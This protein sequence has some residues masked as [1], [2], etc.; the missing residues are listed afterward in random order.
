MSRKI[1]NPRAHGLLF[2][3]AYF[4]NLLV[5]NQ[6]EISAQP[7]LS[8][9]AGS[10]DSGCESVT[11]TIDVDYQFNNMQCNTINWE[12]SYAENGPYLW[13]YFSQ[14]WATRSPALGVHDE[15]VNGMSFDVTF[16]N[17]YIIDGSTYSGNL[18]IRAKT[19]Q[20]C[21]G[22]GQPV[23]SNPVLVRVSQEQPS[24]SQAWSNNTMCTGETFDQ[25]FNPLSGGIDGFDWTSTVASGNFSARVESGTI[26]FPSNTTSYSWG[27]TLTNTSAE[28]GEVEY[29]F[30]PK[31][32]YCSNPNDSKSFTVY[33]EPSV[34]AGTLSIV[35][36]Q[37]FYCEGSSF[38]LSVQGASDGYD[39]VYQKDSDSP[40]TW[41]L[42]AGGESGLQVDTFEE[43]TKFRVRI[44]SECDQPTY[45]NEV[46][47]NYQA[48]PVFEAPASTVTLSRCSGVEVG[49]SVLTDISADLSWTVTNTSGLVSGY[50]TGP[51]L[52][53]V[54]SYTIDD[55]LVNDS[56]EVESITY[57]FTAEKNGCSSAVA[58]VIVNVQPENKAGTLSVLTPTLCQSA[59]SQT[60]TLELDGREGA[61]VD[62]LFK[63]PG[64]SIFLITNWPNG[65]AQTADFDLS[66]YTQTSTDL[67]YEFKVKSKATSCILTED[68]ESDIVT[69]T[70]KAIPDLTVS[71]VDGDQNTIADGAILCHGDQIS[72][73]ASSSVGD[74]HFSWSRQ[75]SGGTL[76][77]SNGTETGETVT[78]TLNNTGSSDATVVYIISPKNDPNGANCIGESQTFS[79]TIKPQSSHGDLTFNSNTTS[80]RY[81]VGESVNIQV[82]AEGNFANQVE[83]ERR[84]PGGT[85][86]PL[87]IKTAEQSVNVLI[88]ETTE[89]KS[90]AIGVCLITGSRIETVYFDNTPSQTNISVVDADAI[91]CNGQPVE[92]LLTSDIAD[93]L[94]FEW[95]RYKN[96][97]VEEDGRGTVLE[98]DN[99]FLLSDHDVSNDNNVND[100]DVTYRY[101]VTAVNILNGQCTGPT[102][103]FNITVPPS[104]NVGGPMT[105]DEPV[106]CID[107]AGTSPV[108]L[109]AHPNLFGNSKW[110]KI[111]STVFQSLVVHND[112]ESMPWVDI[113]T[114]ETS[115]TQSIGESHYF[116]IVLEEECTYDVFGNFIGGSYFDIDE[117]V[118]IPGV[119]E[120]INELDDFDALCSEESF[121]QILEPSSQ[122]LT[123]TVSVEVDGG[124]T[125]EPSD[126]TFETPSI[127]S[128]DHQLIHSIENN[129]SETVRINYTITPWIV[130]VPGV[131]ECDG[132]SRTFYANV[133]PAGKP[134]TLTLDNGPFCDQ[135]SPILSQSGNVGTTVIQFQTDLD[136]EDWEDD[137][138]DGMDVSIDD[139]L[140]WSTWT[141]QTVNQTHTF[142]VKST[143]ESDPAIGCPPTVPHSNYVLFVIGKPENLD[144]GTPDLVV[145]P[146]CGGV[147]IT[148]FDTDDAVQERW[149]W[150]GSQTGMSLDNSAESIAID[151]NEPLPALGYHRTYLRQYFEGCWADEAI[152]I[153]YQNLLRPTDPIAENQYRF[154]P[155]TVVFDAS[156]D[157]ATEY[158]WYEVGGTEPID[159]ND[160]RFEASIIGPVTYEVAAVSSNGCVSTNRTVVEGDIYP[161]PFLEQDDSY[162]QELGD[163]IRLSAKSPYDD[164]SYLSS[165]PGV[166]VEWFKDGVVVHTGEGPFDFSAAGIYQLRVTLPNGKKYTTGG[167]R[168]RNWDNDPVA[169]TLS[170]ETTNEPAGGPGL[171]SINYTRTYTARNEGMAQ[172]IFDMATV[173]EDLMVDTDYFD[174]LGRTIQSVSKGSSPAGYDLVQPMEY[175][176]LGRT[177]KQYLGYSTDIPDEATGL[178]RGNALAE[179]YAFYDREVIGLPSSRFAYSRMKYED[180]PL[181]RVLE[182]AVPGEIYLPGD[183]W[184]D[185][186]RK[187]SSSFTRS[188]RYALDKEIHHYT[189]DDKTI[190]NDPSEDYADHTLVVTVSTDEMGSTLEEYS[191]LEGE[192]LMKRVKDDEG[193]WIETNYIYDDFGNLRVILT[194][195]AKIKLESPDF[196]PGVNGSIINHDKNL[197]HYEGISYLYTPSA[198]ITLKDGFR[199]R[200]E[201]GS[202]SIKKSTHDDDGNGIVYTTTNIH[203]QLYIY[204]Y[205]ER[206]QMIAS[207]DPGADWSYYVYDRWGRQV[208]MQ[209]PQMRED[210]QAQW[211]FFKYDQEGREVLSG[212]LST[213]KSLEVIR[214]EARA[215]TVHYETFIDATDAYSLNNAYPNYITEADLLSIT[216]YDNYDFGISG[217]EFTTYTSHSG[218]QVISTDQRD[219]NSLGGLVTGGKLRVLDAEGTWL[220]SVVYY[221]EDY[222]VI[223]TVSDNHL[224]NK[225]RTYTWYDFLGT[226]TETVT[227]YNEGQTTAFEP[228]EV[229]ITNRY[230]YDHR[231]RLIGLYHRIDDRAEVKLAEYSYNELG[232]V[233]RKDLHP[234]YTPT[235][236]L[237]ELDYTYDIR[238]AL[239]AINDVEDANAGSAELSDVFGMSL[240]YESG[241]TQNHF[242]GQIAGMKWFSRYGTETTPTVSHYGYQYDDLGRMSLADYTGDENFSVR[243]DDYDN[244]GNIKE[245]TRL[246]RFG[247]GSDE[248]DKLRYT[249]EGD[250]LRKVE[251][252][253]GSAEGY[254]DHVDVDEELSYDQAGNLMIERNKGIEQI[255]YNYLSLPERVDM[256]NDTYLSYSYDA[257]GNRLSSS[258][259]VAGELQYTQYYH[260]EL[261]YE[262]STLGTRLSQIQHAEG[263]VID[264]LFD[265]EPGDPN[266]PH[267]WHATD[268]QYFITDHLGNTRAILSADEVRQFTFRASMEDP[269]EEAIYFENVGLVDPGIRSS[270]LINNYS[271]DAGATHSARLNGTGHIIGPAMTYRVQKGD[272]VNMKAYARYSTGNDANLAAGALASTLNNSFWINNSFSEVVN[273]TNPFTAVAN[274]LMLLPN[275][276]NGVPKAYLTY[277]FLNEDFQ[278]IDDE[279]VGY[280][281]L[282]ITDE[283]L[284][285]H[286]ELM[287]DRTFDENGYLY[288]FVSN[289]SPVDVFF[290]D[291]TISLNMSQ[292]D[293][294]QDYYPFGGRFRAYTQNLSEVNRQFYQGKEEE[295]VANIY[296]F[297]ARQY[298]A[299]LGR[300]LGVDPQ[301]QFASPYA[302]MGNNPVLMVDPNGEFAFASVALN[303]A[304]AAVA[305]GIIGGIID[306]K[307]GVW[308]GALAGLAAYG[309]ATNVN[310][311]SIFKGNGSG[312]SFDI[313][314][315]WKMATPENIALID[316]ALKQGTITIE[317]IFSTGNTLNGRMLTT[318]EYYQMEDGIF[319][320]DFFPRPASG[321]IELSP[322]APID[323]IG[324]PGKAA[325]RAGAKV[326]TKIA[327]K[328]RRIQSISRQTIQSSP[329]IKSLGAA[330]RGFSG[331]WKSVNQLNKMVKS[332]RAPRGIKRFDKG[333]ATKNLPEDEVHFNDGSSLYRSGRWRHNNG[334]KI[335]NKQREFLEENGWVIPDN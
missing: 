100:V 301:G 6:G 261:L 88:D 202:F 116:R 296:D 240:H 329:K 39:I 102:E 314:K 26:D 7:R 299:S 72:I 221:D 325:F 295:E 288:V 43:T 306:G 283:A 262:E 183:N 141:A 273:A 265:P 126:I 125:G 156:A 47:M 33:V 223:Q 186:D 199:A 17:T 16:N 260:G 192:L 292:I 119:K 153:N 226:T 248:I 197:Y 68:L 321:A 14:V 85:W 269:A 182:T 311:S 31:N 330:A 332:G 272:Q 235:A 194:P 137:I 210:E 324:G 35:P 227:V 150:Q 30:T 146:T 326:V 136:I 44:G 167:I 327:V 218:K 120:I 96:G 46:I 195:E 247:N 8:I 252:V 1:L 94:S 12:A 300:F 211:L 298:D 114:N 37:N 258:L 165:H 322:I 10:P 19:S 84:T 38:D 172:G 168:L 215:H 32:D 249:Y 310:W 289:H 142:R 57:E 135:G 64:S 271:P 285:S 241:F 233:I 130:I 173:P 122:S 65:D 93:N 95:T 284:G 54:D 193:D 53:D 307:D 174:G 27:Q 334:H 243:V 61:D 305:G 236:P 308:K 13:N 228:E 58:K 15:I 335:T 73:T 82:Q 59:Q 144:L 276:D 159:I 279:N 196:V 198:R 110:Q 184:D 117:V 263:R 323:L 191:N 177:P 225:D 62:L 162:L 74:P 331:N 209:E 149:Y 106:L 317:P 160:G 63:E 118:V 254:D 67:T 259:F 280:G 18:W 214:Q 230:A 255:T 224:G 128:G 187:T 220:K 104:H 11:V 180:S 190:S 264:N 36:D 87:G 109:S 238:G 154:G 315:V 278:F 170:T 222:Q 20:A 140:Y 29:T 185:P 178:Y 28:L 245:L 213:D 143:S 287:L 52:T 270:L 309:I 250:Q 111:A 302:G 91:I 268:Y 257:A 164:P 71:A 42:Y 108:T 246:G 274:E 145:E 49:Y 134:G 56:D 201:D 79:F 23:Y 124:F 148:K 158:H 203:D 157:H 312:P 204:E 229:T 200:H 21:A 99:E 123:Y 277:I 89:F 234:D 318:D 151:N 69:V 70:L 66:G 98:V 103:E 80:Q 115:I 81:C 132:P 304:S 24:F 333:R 242:D 147:T 266:A 3:L 217:Y 2:V 41:T 267:Q 139:D 50:S 161:Y 127:A 181:N 25:T 282:Q 253:S 275:G 138:L 4:C 92:A 189:I 152:A 129:S 51:S 113:A 55:K 290:D 101:E 76:N 121:T 232:A 281:Y 97:E 237:Q 328:A 251:D 297:H 166:S 60:V 155:G 176:E 107:G 78:H 171:T 175:D 169:L 256:G 5:S 239:T 207:K 316:P 291:L 131:E 320:G 22:T 9:Q 112:I 212:L 303:Y 163:D 319:P 86:V 77:L 231:D 40:T 294:V 34:T 206:Q 313:D 293:Q 244:N 133:K 105:I 219:V 188:N 90:T 216:F 205:D 48:K 179:Q 45:S 83:I 208:M 75:V 286:E